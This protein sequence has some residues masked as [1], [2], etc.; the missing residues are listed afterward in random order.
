[1]AIHPICHQDQEIS[2]TTIE[3]MRTRVRARLEETTAA[4]WTDPEIDECVTGALEAYSWL[5][6]RE[7]IASVVVAEG[8]DAIAFPT[9]AIDIRRVMLADG[10]VVPRR[11]V[12]L[13]WTRDEELAWETFANQ[14][15]FSQPLSAQ[16]MVIWHTAAMTLADL[17]PSDEGLIVL[18][19]VAQALEV[20]AVQDFKRGG[21]SGSARYDAVIQRARDDYER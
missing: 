5:F 13:R 11:G 6:P 7:A 15:L 9:G 14:L 10:S 12:P 20:R 17:P 8:T 3:A 21:P 2:M 18:G 16:T 19:A 4:V 1:M